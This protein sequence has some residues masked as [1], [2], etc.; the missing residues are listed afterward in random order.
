[1]QFT[2]RFDTDWQG[3]SRSGETMRSSL[4]DSNSGRAEFQC[5]RTLPPARSELVDPGSQECSMH[6][7][8]DLPGDDF[9][10]VRRRADARWYRQL[11]ENRDA[12]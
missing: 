6:I 3:N 9:A 4:Y 5:R 2:V 12:G 7:E 11:K 10:S 8:H 1:M